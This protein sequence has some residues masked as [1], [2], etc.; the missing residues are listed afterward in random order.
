MPHTNNNNNNKASMG[1]DIDDLDF[2]MQ[3]TDNN[4]IDEEE[5]FYDNGI[6]DRDAGAAN[7]SAAVKIKLMNKRDNLILPDIS[8]KSGSSQIG[9][10][11]LDNRKSHKEL[12]HNVLFD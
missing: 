1:I 7:E 5:G 4:N 2:K 9:H 11:M 8:Q 6:N 10:S 3:E 12:H